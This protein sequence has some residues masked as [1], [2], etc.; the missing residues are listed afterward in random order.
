MTE[1]TRGNGGDDT[2]RPFRVEVA[3][4]ELTEFEQPRL[5]S[6]EMRASFRSL[7]K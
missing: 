6:E 2:I 5:F 1:G 7:R 4:A 3:E